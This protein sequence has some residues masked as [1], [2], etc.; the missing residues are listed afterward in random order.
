MSHFSRIILLILVLLGGFW[1]WKDLGEVDEVEQVDEVAEEEGR[2][3]APNEFVSDAG[4]ILRVLSP[5]P[6][7]VISS[8]LTIT[9]EA[10]GTWYFEGSFPV[11]LV[12][13]DD[14]VIAEG[15][16]TAQ[17]DWMTESFVPFTATLTFTKS[18]NG[19]SG[20]LILHR[21]N[22]SGLSENDDAIEIPILFQ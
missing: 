11:D 16:A 3:V 21:D 22:P 10:P 4:V 17:D 8:P 20:T 14:L 19:G 15:I 1:L 18:S 6:D 2:T 9:G 5:L 13:G 12:D 7:S